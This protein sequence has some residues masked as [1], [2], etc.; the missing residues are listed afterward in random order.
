M[1]KNKTSENELKISRSKRKSQTIIL[2]LFWEKYSSYIHTRKNIAEVDYFWNIDKSRPIAIR[3]P[4][5]WDTL[6]K[7]AHPDKIMNLIF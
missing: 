2:N 6:E 5:G 7:F 3:R 4:A 1:S